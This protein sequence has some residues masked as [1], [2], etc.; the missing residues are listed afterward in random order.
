MVGAVGRQNAKTNRKDQPMTPTL[1][2]AGDRAVLFELGST[3]DAETNARIIALAA[4]LDAAHWPGVT[5]IVPTYRS[6]LVCYDPM[7]LRG[8]DLE[9]RLLAVGRLWRVP[10]LYGGEVGQDLDALAALK[11]L[12]PDEVIALHSGAEYRVYMIG[13]APGFAYLGG[14]PER[15]HTPRLPVPRQSIPAGAI[16]IG[17][18]Q[19]SI[20]SVAGP[21]GW[22]FVG[23]TPWN[24]FDAA[25]ANPVLLRAGDRVRFEAVTPTQA[26]AIAEG[27]ANRTIHPEPQTTG[28]DD[29]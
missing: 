14:L 29:A 9:T 22:R 4:R 24:I 10:C 28:A 16:G 11:G 25:A 18:Q 23:W 1:L 20:S 13:F 17:G 3:I 8:A 2:P 7:V 6:L 21:S 19:G 27:L 12:T 26:Q 5:E 15:L